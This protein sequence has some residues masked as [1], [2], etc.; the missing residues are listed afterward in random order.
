METMNT[1]KHAH[2]I[3]IGGIGMSAV[4]EV[5]LERGYRI[6][7]S[8]LNESDQVHM[9]RERGAV[10]GVPQKAENITDDIDVVVRSTAIRENN[11]EYRT[12][13]EKG[14]PVVHRSEMLGYLMREQ[15]AICVAG[16]H[17]KTTTSSMI[18][19]CLEKN[20]LDPT[21]VVGGVIS[22]IGSNAKNGKG[23]WFV[24]EAD[25]SDGS[26]INLLP[27]YAVI[28]NIEED[29]LDHYKDINEI[30]ESFKK[31]LHKTNPNGRCLLCADNDES[32]GIASQCPVP[33][34][35]YGFHERSQY[36]IMNHKQVG[37]KNEADIYN[38]DRFIGHLELQVP[39]KHN[40]ANA[41][42][43]VV[44]GLDVG[45]SF[46][47][48][49]RVLKEYKGTRRR[50]Q[51]QGTVNGIA[52]YDDYAHHPTEIMATLEAAR[53]VNDGRVVA[54]FQPHRYS[55]TQFLA[56]EFAKALSQADAVMLLDV[57]PAG[58]A[59][60]EGVSSQL[61]VDQVDPG[62]HAQ[63]VND[64]YLTSGFISTLQPGDLVLVLGAGS[65][66]K[67]APLIVKALEETYGK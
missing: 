3:G 34:K 48:I 19:L 53:A 55:R 50:F 28:T 1:I 35:T 45:L 47:Q 25:E 37:M 20:G 6:S 52:V 14:I 12:A 62:K 46:E 21:I 33:M 43:A 44:V 24:A 16:S 31:F 9:L 61:I 56:K 57:F 51:H 30:R 4:A 32:F 41:T 7:G 13:Q 40:I 22:D 39:G 15:K 8:D 64:E 2:F 23:E 18:A 26:F 5:M 27:W 49:A 66:W 42:A 11:V 59:P 10:V 54:I 65:I 38:G 36:R 29:H 58:E 60:I 67:Q 63:V 17:G